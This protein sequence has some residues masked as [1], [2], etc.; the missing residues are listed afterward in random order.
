MKRAELIERN[1]LDGTLEALA[2]IAADAIVAFRRGDTVR[3][4]LVMSAV[5]DRMSLADVAP[6]YKA[7][8]AIRLGELALDLDDAERGQQS[9]GDGQD[10][11]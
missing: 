6:W 11:P 5:V 9:G 4:R 8:I 10:N 3:A 1:G 7:T 2:P